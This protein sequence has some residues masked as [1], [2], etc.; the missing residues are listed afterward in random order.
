MLHSILNKVG[1]FTESEAAHVASMMT[2]RRYKKNQWLLAEGIVCRGISL[3][4]S[5]AA[6]QYAVND[7]DENIIDLY[8][9]KDWV[10]NYTSFV[11][12]KPSAT[13]IKAYITT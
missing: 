4:V 2:P 10:M 9:E 13:I 3:L 5:G 6:Y 7:I 11:S 8:T 1:R 12:Q